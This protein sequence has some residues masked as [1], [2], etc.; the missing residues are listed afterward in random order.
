MN[1]YTLQQL[2]DL[3][4]YDEKKSSQEDVEIGEGKNVLEVLSEKLR[5]SLNTAGGGKHND[6]SREDSSVITSLL[7]AGYSPSDTFTTFCSSPRGKDAEERK[8]GHFTDYVNRTIRK[9]LGFL[10]P[11]ANN[12]NGHIEVDFSRPRDP[13]PGQGI[14]PQSADTVEVEKTQW[15]WA[16][17]IPLGKITVLAGDPGMGKSTMAL[18]I[19]SRVSNGTF[20]PRSDSRTVAGHCLIASAEDAA[21]DTIVPRLIAA[22]ANLKKI[23]VIREVRIDDEHHYLSLPR[24]LNRLK[25]LVVRKGARMLIIDPLNAFLEKGTDTYKDQDIRLV[26]AP[27]EALAEET[28]VAILIIAHL[29]KKEDSSTLYRVGGSIGFIGAARSVLAVSRTQKDVRVLY[30]LKSN[31]AKSPPSL[32]YDIKQIKREKEKEEWK[33]EKTV[34]SSTVKWI[35]QIQFDPNQRRTTDSSKSEGEA[36]DFLRQILV[37]SELPTDDIFEE[38]KKAGIGKSQLMH[39]KTE[40]GLKISHKKGRWYWALPS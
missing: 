24:D 7:S 27:L 38:G 35:G 8:Q 4:I 6:A 16:G 3:G 20:L 39:I 33:G 18:D 25:K 21:A 9:A 2:K 1:L 28:G 31:L 12:K 10:G 34:H 23:S 40:M 30:S 15:L 37:D 17:Y 5:T 29:N 32:A 11:T 13:I 19:V 36:E 26:L 22:K 14:L